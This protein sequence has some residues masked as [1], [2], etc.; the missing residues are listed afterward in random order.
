MKKWIDIIQSI[1]AIFSILLNVVLIILIIKKSPK[2][3]GT[4]KYLLLFIAW[5]EIFYSLLDVILS[6]IAFSHD[7]IFLMIVSVK[8]SIFSKDV[9]FL[10][11]S[12]FCAFFG[13]SMGMFAVNFIYRFFVATGSERLKSFKGAWIICWLMIPCIYGGIWGL[14]CYSVLGP[15][16]EINEQI[17][18]DILLIFDWSVEDI[19]YLGPYVYQ[20]QHNGSYIIDINSIIAIF[21]A[22]GIIVSSLIAIFYCGIKCYMNLEILMPDNKSNRFKNLQSQLF[23]ALVT[24]TLIPVILLHLPISLIFI[25]TLM[26]KNLGSLSA[27]VSVT[28]ALFPMLDPLPTIFI[29]KSYREAIFI[30][31]KWFSHPQE[32][33]NAPQMRH[34]VKD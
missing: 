11:D 31:E 18:T 32:D 7:S 19:T 13:V 28:I 30:F 29:V 25:F 22:F 17:R 23:F 4:Y 16:V 12:I 15:T 20:K 24:Q 6:P 5:F 8:N 33:V 2:E 3:L 14:L 9:L 1:A 26:E 27:I 21:I 10:L 34:D